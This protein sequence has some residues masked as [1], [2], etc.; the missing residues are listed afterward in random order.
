M[1]RAPTYPS[2]AELKIIAARI[3]KIAKAGDKEYFPS[4]KQYQQD[5]FRDRV[6]ETVLRLRT[7]DRRSTVTRP[8]GFLIE[9][10]NAARTLHKKFIRMKATDREW[11]EHIKQ[12]QSQL[13]V[14]ELHDVETA[15][16]NMALLFD[17]ALGRATP[18][19]KPPKSSARYALFA[20]LGTFKPRVRDQSL[21]ELV[22]GLLAAAR[23]TG[24]KLTFNVDSESGTLANVLDHLRPYL[25][26]GLVPQ[27]IRSRTIVR[28]KNEFDR[29]QAARSLRGGGG[30]KLCVPSSPSVSSNTKIPRRKAI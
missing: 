26:P 20:K 14:G 5:V 22:F 29:L 4:N 2:N 9:C 23:D 21:R 24:G 15:I 12:T 8:V 6:I 18:V 1:P 13:L 11:V 16:L 10:A 30:R 7:R 19:P 25:P 28:L 17:A 27:P 3:A